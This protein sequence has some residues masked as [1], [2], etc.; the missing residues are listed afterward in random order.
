MLKERRYN[1]LLVS[2][3]EKFNQQISDLMSKSIYPDITISN[4]IEQAKRLLIE[5]SF[6][7]VLINSPV[8]SEK[9]FDFALSISDN[10]SSGILLF[11]KAVDYDEAYFKMHEFGIYVLA[12]PT[13]GDLF[14][15]SLRILCSTRD[16]I[17]EAKK[18]SLSYKSKLDEIN[19]IA[20]AKMIIVKNLHASENEAHKMIE[21]NAMN[22]RINKKLS[23][24]MFIK[25]YR[26]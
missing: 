13:E 2:S 7:I 6:D 26:N 4:N 19:I 3:S 17:N 1:I 18:D 9:G 16:K 8:A 15:Q 12:K 21:Q 11:S 5:R 10:D 23:A 14:I 25:K 24:E 20:E 22:L